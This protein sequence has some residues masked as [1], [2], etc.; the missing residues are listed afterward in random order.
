MKFFVKSKTLQGIS[1]LLIFALKEVFDLDVTENEAELWVG[2]LIM[3]LSGIYAVY[4]RIVAKD[5]L[6]VK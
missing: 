2:A 4:G 3:V 6:T 5:A 1:V